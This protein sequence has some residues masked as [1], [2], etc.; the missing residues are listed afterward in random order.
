MDAKTRDQCFLLGYGITKIN[1]ASGSMNFISIQREEKETCT[2]FNKDFT[3]TQMPRNPWGNKHVDS[4][5][6]PHT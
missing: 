6:K 2:I 5:P 4:Q 3:N 1:H